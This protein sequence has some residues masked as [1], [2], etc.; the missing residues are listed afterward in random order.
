MAGWRRGRL[1]P[2]VLKSLKMLQ[3]NHG[4][5]GWRRWRRWRL[6]PKVFK[7]SITLLKQLCNS[8]DVYI[9]L[10]YYL[11]VYLIPFFKY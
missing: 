8:L 7:S 2:K 4:I 6:I 11:Y 5:A 9:T 10:Y 1:I 3:R